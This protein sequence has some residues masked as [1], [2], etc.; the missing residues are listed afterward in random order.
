MTVHFYD[1]KGGGGL[2][3]FL[4]RGGGG[5]GDWKSIEDYD[6]AEL[7]ENVVKMEKLRVP[8]LKKYLQQHSR[9]IT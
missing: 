7:C 9:A 2:L 5:G 3:D 8:K 1:H 6:W 4:G